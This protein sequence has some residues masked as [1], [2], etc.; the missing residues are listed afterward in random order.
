MHVIYYPPGETLLDGEIVSNKDLAARITAMPLNQATQ[1]IHDLRSMQ[2]DTWRMEVL[3]QTVYYVLESRERK[4]LGQWSQWRKMLI[5]G[6]YKQYES[7]QEANKQK[8]YCYGYN[9]E[10]VEERRYEI[11]VVQVVET[12]L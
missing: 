5:E 11:R 10:A 1:T 2:G 6:K 9:C 7:E 8:Q 12:V 3:D 4:I